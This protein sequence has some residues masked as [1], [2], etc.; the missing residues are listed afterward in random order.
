MQPPFISRCRSIFH[1][2]R[3]VSRGFWG[4]KRVIVLTHPSHMAATIKRGMNTST[5][6]VALALSVNCGLRA[7]SL[8]DP[9]PG[10]EFLPAAPLSLSVGVAPVLPGFG[11]NE[12]T[13]LPVSADALTPSA[14]FSVDMKKAFLPPK[15]DAL[16]GGAGSRIGGR[17][18]RSIAGS[19]SNP[20]S[21]S[22]S[23]VAPVTGG[24]GVQNAAPVMAVA[25]PEPGTFFTGVLLLGVCASRY[26]SRTPRH[27]HI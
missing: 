15:G 9:A 2:Q 25:V 13:L 21:G 3:L 1:L 7:A 19:G 20:V 26:G 5:F 24:S 6:A 10:A 18:V 17:R 16:T 23:S 27:S 22:G 12:C 4:S 8:T 14:K 11:S